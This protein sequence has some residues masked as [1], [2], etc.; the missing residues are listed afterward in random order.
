[1]SAP[2]QIAVKLISQTRCQPDA[3]T[4]QKRKT[5]KGTTE[6]DELYKW[7]DGWMDGRRNVDLGGDR[8]SGGGPAGRRDRQVVQEIIMG[9]CEI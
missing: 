5:K 1:V 7:M 2:A 9:L 4:K 8:R 3:N 6:H